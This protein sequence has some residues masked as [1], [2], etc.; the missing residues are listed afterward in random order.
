M[1]NVLYQGQWKMSSTNVSQLR[2][3]QRDYNHVHQAQNKAVSGHLFMM[4][5]Y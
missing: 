2:D 1:E 4:V 5:L 3:H